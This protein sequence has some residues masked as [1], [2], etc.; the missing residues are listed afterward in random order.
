MRWFLS[1]GRRCQR[2][3]FPVRQESVSLARRRSEVTWENDVEHSGC[4]C[5]ADTEEVTGSNPVAPTI[6]GLTSGNAAALAITAL[7]S[8][9]AGQVAV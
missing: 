5:F 1:A 3:R 9:N 7:S 2:E 6:L 4:P 8:G